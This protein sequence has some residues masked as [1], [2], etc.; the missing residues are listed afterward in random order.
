MQY[1]RT[2]IEHSVAYNHPHAHAL[3]GTRLEITPH[4]VS[5]RLC[6]CVCASCESFVQI[7]T[8]SRTLRAFTRWTRTILLYGNHPV[9]NSTNPTETLARLF[10]TDETMKA[11]QFLDAS[12]P[13]LSRRCRMLS[14]VRHFFAHRLPIYRTDLDA[15]SDHQCSKII[16]FQSL[17]R[18]RLIQNTAKMQTIFVSFLFLV[19]NFVSVV[20]YVCI[21]E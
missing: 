9:C 17:S 7:V 18:S 4:N 3:D 12:I 8:H 14:L 15:T 21:F 10:A 13:N 16:P 19:T 20:A 5:V 11:K 2:Q 1:T 6:V